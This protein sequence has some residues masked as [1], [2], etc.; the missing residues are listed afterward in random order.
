TIVALTK[1]R[2]V[3]E[4]VGTFDN[5]SAET[6]VNG[7]AG[8]SPPAG[9]ATLPALV[10]DPVVIA[11]DAVTVVLLASPSGRLVELSSLSIAD[12]W[13]SYD[14]TSLAR[15]ARGGAGGG[16]AVAPHTP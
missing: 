6:I 3:V 13:S 16:G 5:W 15:V 11:K 7:V 14:L 8:S 9:H 4:F 12:P 10:G 1:S 2:R